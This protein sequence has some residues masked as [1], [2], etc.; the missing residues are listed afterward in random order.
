[1]TNPDIIGLSTILGTRYSRFITYP[2]GEAEKEAAQ[3]IRVLSNIGI[4]SLQFSGS[5]YVDGIPVLGKGCAGIVIQANLNNVPVALKIRRLDSDRAGLLD[6]GRLLHLANS[7]NVGPRLLAVSRDFLL[8]ELID[9]LPLFKWM[10]R[11]HK[12]P[13]IQKILRDLLFACFKLDA[14]GLDHGELSHAPRNVLVSSRNKPCIVDFESASTNR[15]VS[16][17]TALIQYFLFGQLAKAMGTKLYRNRKTV[18]KTLSEYKL[19][20]SVSNFYKILDTL[21]LR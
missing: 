19:D 15:R 14:I 10:A 8:M 11:S 21:A 18:L 13:K 2:D 6:E 4:S 1:M 7:V 5:T 9:G 3:R 17:V 12:K 16:N 20:G